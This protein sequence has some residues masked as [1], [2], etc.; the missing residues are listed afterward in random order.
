MKLRALLFVLLSVWLGA[1][2][3]QTVRA[4]NADAELVAAG[5]AIVAGQPLTVAVRIKH[6]RGWHTYWRV[7]GDSGLPTR[8]K[9]SLPAGWSA[10]PIL[11]PVPERQ[12]IGP[13]VNFG[14]GDEILL[15]TDLAPPANL[16]LGIDVD[17]AAHVNFLICNEVCIPSGADLKLKLPV[18]GSAGPSSRAP[19]FIATRALIPRPM[20]LAEAAA[21]IDGERIR[22][23]YR[24]AGPLSKLA[25]FPLEEGRIEPAA[26]QPLRV[27][28]DRTVLYLTAAKPRSEFEQLQ[29]VLVGNG[30]P[31]HADQGGWAGEISVPLNPGAVAV[32]AD[33]APAEVTAAGMLASVWLALI[34]AL[35]GGVILNLMPCVF[36]ILSLKLLSLLQHQRAEDAAHVKHASL[37]VHGIAFAIGVVASFVLLAGLMLALRAGGSQMGWGFQLQRPWVVAALTVLFFVIGL[38]LL[39][40][41]EVAIGGL[42]TNSAAAQRLR[43]DRV[44]GSFGTG[45]LAVVVAAPCTAPFM[46]AALGYAVTQPAAV[47]L[48]VFAALGVG[49]A[50]PYLVLSF[51]PATLKWLPRPGAWMERFK[52]VM[53][54]PM[55]ATCVWLLWVLGQQV[56]VHA[57]GLTLASLVLAGFGLW[58][59]GLAQRG[60]R[61]WRWVA[62][63][64]AALAAYAVVVASSDDM[65]ASA[66]AVDS[67][68]AWQAWSTAEVQRQTAAGKPVFVDFTA[69]WCVT[70]QANKQ[71]V[72]NTRTVAEALDRKGVVRLRA[73]WTN[74]D[75]A[76]T[77][78]LA[79]FRRSGVPLY[80]IYDRQGRTQILPELLTERTVLDTVDKL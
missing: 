30:G 38:N 80:V 25:F 19:Q 11:W 3:A 71:L 73:D 20:P 61:G 10:G 48:L 63:G 34:G 32:V 21:T 57:L 7:P 70:C 36:P 58:A 4:D 62:L 67:K 2:S 47:A 51:A 13:L 16:K 27:E 50:L 18:K 8:I 52:Q 54:F 40:T 28:G 60:V 37:R 59:L 43:P 79:R 75:D 14:Y 29:G 35:L 56:N 5:D 76:I 74:Q 49:M 77:R 23:S 65:R 78:E 26:P 55:F 45:V 6:D 12:V 46:G 1:L 64:A 44:S 24:E 69:A 68:A 53:A 41:F 17:L 66:A 42:L 9:W 15:L 39:G 72:L 33:A 22:L 31:A